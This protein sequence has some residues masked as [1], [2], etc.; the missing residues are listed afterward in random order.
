MTGP[1]VLGPVLGMPLEGGDTYSKREVK[2]EAVSD[3]F[4]E[5]SEKFRT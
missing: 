1:M 4:K 3:K 5:K 2:K